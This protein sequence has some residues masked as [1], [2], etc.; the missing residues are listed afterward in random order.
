MS[1]TKVPTRQLGR[2]GPTIPILGLGLMGLSSKLRGAATYYCFHRYFPCIAA[3]C[4]NPSREAFYGAVPSDEERLKLL[5]RAHELGCTHWDSAALYGDSE[6][7]L[8][9]WFQRTGKRKDVRPV[10][11]QD[12]AHTSQ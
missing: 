11:P 6:D 7:L 9:K 3:D 12:W 10:R 2:D 5:D 8:G 4:P 1:S